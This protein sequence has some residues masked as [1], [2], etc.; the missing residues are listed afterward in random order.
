MFVWDAER[1]C[2]QQTFTFHEAAVCDVD[3]KSDSKTFVSCA[4][5]GA[6]VISAIGQQQPLRSIV[7]YP[8]GIKIFNL[9][10]N[11]DKQIFHSAL[12]QSSS[13]GL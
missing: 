3:W 6:I 7:D 13:L 2:L 10:Y 4:Y 12:G 11:S 5:D 9:R 1:F 8:V